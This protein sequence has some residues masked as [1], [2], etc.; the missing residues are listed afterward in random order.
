[1]PTRLAALTPPGPDRA[2]ARPSGRALRNLIQSLTAL[3]SDALMLLK[4]KRWLALGVGCFAAGLLI[5][6][7]KGGQVQRLL[8]WLKSFD[9]QEE[10][11]DSGG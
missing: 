5:S 2:E 1:M 3:R 10:H 8:T 6:L 9:D 11:I 7:I 4:G